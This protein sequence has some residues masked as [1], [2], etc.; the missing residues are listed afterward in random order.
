MRSIGQD[1]WMI[2]FD[3]LSREGIAGMMIKSWREKEQ[4]KQSMTPVTDLE[5]KKARES[6]PMVLDLLDS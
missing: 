4:R 2:E 3:G 6:V 5:K 1:D